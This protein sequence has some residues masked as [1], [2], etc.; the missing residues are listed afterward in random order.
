[1]RHI[2]SSYRNTVATMYIAY[3]CDNIL[4]VHII[5]LRIL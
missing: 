4:D 5:L 2:D 1:M 3:S